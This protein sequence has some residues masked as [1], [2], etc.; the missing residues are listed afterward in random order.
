MKDGI[1]KQDGTSRLVKAS[2]PATYE[3]FRTMAENGTLTMDVLFN[4]VGWQQLPTFLNKA[5]LLQDY[6]AALHGLATTATPNDVFAKL[7]M[8]YGYYGF[9]VTVRFSD[10]LPAV[11]VLL[12]GLKDF[13]GN[14]AKTDENGRCRAAV[15]ASK[16]ATVKFSNYIGI[17]DTSVQITAQ[18]EVVFTPVTIILERDTT[19]KLIQTSQTLRV[20]A[21]VPVDMCIVGGGASG[22][23][24]DFSATE[25]VAGGGG[26]YAKNILN[27]ILNSSIVNLVV[28]SGGVAQNV[29]NAGPYAGGNSSVTY[30]GVTVTANG[31]SGSSGKGSSTAGSAGTNGSVHVFEDSSLPIPGGGGGGG[32]TSSATH[33]AGGLSYGGTGSW[34][35]ASN[36][37][38]A[39]NATG[40]GGGGGGGACRTSYGVA[41]AGSGAA[42]GLY[43]R[44]KAP[45]VS[46]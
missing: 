9:D 13:S 46:A 25:A 38:H 20:L 17:V 30:D 8:P 26:G 34:V 39:T 12:D 19:M 27:I 37:E 4:A 11:N 24:A 43:I 18:D 35:T 21:G 40:P 36:R 33:L 2:F 44:V 31:A 14:T 23:S 29:T 15:C 22:K 42:G 7:A 1:I 5:N 28:G 3:E 10:G 32:N 6:T 41:Y 16:T 45:E